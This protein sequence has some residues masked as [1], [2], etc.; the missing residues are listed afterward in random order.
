MRPVNA[1]K[2]N[3]SGTLKTVFENEDGSLTFIVK[4]YDENGDEIYSYAY[5]NEYTRQVKEND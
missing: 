2:S 5:T 4:R 3:L 1:P